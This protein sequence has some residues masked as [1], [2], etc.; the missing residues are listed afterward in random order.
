VAINVGVDGAFKV[1]NLLPQPIQMRLYGLD[2][3]QL[4]TGLMRFQP[5]ALLLVHKINGDRFI[6]WDATTQ[7]LTG[8]ECRTMLQCE[9]SP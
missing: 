1:V 7:V 3:R 8:A 5:V 2:Q 6:F 9:T 4:P